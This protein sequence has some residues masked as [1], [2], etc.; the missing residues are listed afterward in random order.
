MHNFEEGDFNNLGLPSTTLYFYLIRQTFF[1][2]R[3]Q[4]GREFP[5]IPPCYQILNFDNHFQL[6]LDK[7]NKGLYESPLSKCY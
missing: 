6:F 4:K 7:K 5:H 1:L 3:Q 2:V